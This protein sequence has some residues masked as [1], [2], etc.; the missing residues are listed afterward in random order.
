MAGERER[1]PCERRD[2]EGEG[3]GE[4]VF[5][6]WGERARELERALERERDAPAAVEAVVESYRFAPDDVLGE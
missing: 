4:G 1:E 5:G 2:C 6:V 3:E